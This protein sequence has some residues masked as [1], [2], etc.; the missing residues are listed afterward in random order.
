MTTWDAI[1]FFFYIRYYLEMFLFDEEV[2]QLVFYFGGR[3][4]PGVVSFA[5]FEEG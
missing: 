1:A 3:V 2:I 4:N 5:A